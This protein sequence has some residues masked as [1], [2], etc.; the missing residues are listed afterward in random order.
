MNCSMDN[1]NE[2]FIYPLIVN[3]IIHVQLDELV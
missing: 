3:S 2:H 1:A